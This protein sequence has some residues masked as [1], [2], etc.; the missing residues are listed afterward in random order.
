MH[1][2]SGGDDAD[3]M[4]YDDRKEN[5]S[6]SVSVEESPTDTWRGIVSSG[7]RKFDYHNTYLYLLVQA[8]N[9]SAI[10]QLID[11]RLD[12]RCVLICQMKAYNDN[13]DNNVK[14][15]ILTKKKYIK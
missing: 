3:G 4:T 8:A 12:F 5:V 2:D 15:N 10:S 9:I 7:C 11:E 6:V 14:R 13:N 1:N